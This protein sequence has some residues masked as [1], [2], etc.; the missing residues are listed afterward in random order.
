[1]IK[2]ND[3]I[4]YTDTY[5]DSVQGDQELADMYGKVIDI[6]TK[7]PARASIKWNDGC[8]SSALIS[9]IEKIRAN[10]PKIE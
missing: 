1:M 3:Y 2:I 8:I 5:L 10:V 9:N 7:K 4:E 6:A